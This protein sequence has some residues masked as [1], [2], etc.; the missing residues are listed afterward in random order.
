MTCFQADAPHP[1]PPPTELLFGNHFKTFGNGFGT[2]FTHGRVQVPPLVCYLRALGEPINRFAAHRFLNISG[3]DG[4]L[5]VA[6]AT[7]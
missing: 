6:A 3:A 2:F 7:L 4:A 5:G 1:P